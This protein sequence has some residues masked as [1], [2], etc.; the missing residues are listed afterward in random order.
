MTDA[1]NNTYI[2][3]IPAFTSNYASFQTPHVCQPLSARIEWM[4]DD[5]N[6]WTVHKQTII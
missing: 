2:Q 3:Y 4:H 6:F 5:I 1:Q